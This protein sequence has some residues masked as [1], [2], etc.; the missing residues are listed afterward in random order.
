[1]L[2]NGFKVDKLNVILGYIKRGI[3]FLNEGGDSFIFFYI[4]QSLFGRLEDNVLESGVLVK[5]GIQ[6]R[7]ISQGEE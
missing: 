1:M 6:G 5:W 2:V 3:E 4:G 7:V